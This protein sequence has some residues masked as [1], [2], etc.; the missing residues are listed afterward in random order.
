MSKRQFFI[1][2][3]AARAWLLKN[4]PPL[5]CSPKQDGRSQGFN[6]RENKKLIFDFAEPIC[7]IREMKTKQTG[8]TKEDEKIL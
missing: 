6:K 8:K 7:R 4:V 2:N 3:P 5:E 1:P